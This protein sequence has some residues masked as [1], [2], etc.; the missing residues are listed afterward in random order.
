MRLWTLIILLLSCVVGFIFSYGLAYTKVSGALFSSTGSA[1]A[2]ATAFV[3]EA[4]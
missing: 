4:E 1:Q 2:P 3:V